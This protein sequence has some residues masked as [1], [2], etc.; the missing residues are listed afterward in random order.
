MKSGQWHSDGLG[1]LVCAAVCGYFECVF[2]CVL[3]AFAA[4]PVNVIFLS[5]SES[6][7]SPY[8]HSSRRL[9]LKTTLT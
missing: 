7:C 2:F 1:L 9:S 5:L 4:V 6:L 3:P 8:S